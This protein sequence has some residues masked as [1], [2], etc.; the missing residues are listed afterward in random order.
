MLGFVKIFHSSHLFR[1]WILVYILET[2]D[3]WIIN[4]NLKVV[5]AKL[6]KSKTVQMVGGHQFFPWHVSQKV[7]VFM[8]D[9]LLLLLFS[10]KVENVDRWIVIPVGIYDLCTKGIVTIKSQT[11]PFWVCFEKKNL[12]RL[13]WFLCDECRVYVKRKNTVD[14]K[15]TKNVS[16]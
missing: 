7:F 13:K 16:H 3:E 1:T 2:Y 4:L 9:H 10:A 6:S 11:L 14:M 15:L 12:F 8:A 5:R